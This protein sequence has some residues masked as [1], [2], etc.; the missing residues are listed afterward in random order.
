MRVSSAARDGFRILIV[1]STRIG[2][3]VSRRS[4]RLTARDTVTGQNE[5]RR[6]YASAPHVRRD[7]KV[8]TIAPPY[9]EREKGKPGESRRRKATRLTR[10]QVV[11]YA[12]RAAEQT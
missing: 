7:P 12:S 5:I 3:A 8:G 11:R 4:D 6:S 9:E 10:A 1:R 2:T